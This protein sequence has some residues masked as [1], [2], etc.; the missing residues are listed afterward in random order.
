MSSDIKH[1]V[2]LDDVDRKALKK[3]NDSQVAVTQFVDLVS[4]QGEARLSQVQEEGREV[5]Q[6]IAKKYDLDLEKCAYTMS[7]DGKQL[8][9]TGVRYS[10]SR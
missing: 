9:L 5:W 8:V 7:N 6:K 1:T 10:Y 4:K 3:L 2:E